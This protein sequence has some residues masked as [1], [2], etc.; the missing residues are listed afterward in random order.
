MNW[1]IYFFYILSSHRIL[2]VDSCFKWDN[3]TSYYTVFK[4]LT[5]S[6][7]VSSTVRS[8][9]IKHFYLIIKLAERSI[10]FKCK[11]DVAIIQTNLHIT[12]SHFFTMLILY[13]TKEPLQVEDYRVNGTNPSKKL[14][15]PNHRKENALEGPETRSLTGNKRYTS[16]PV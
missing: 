9:F 7:V 2:Y 15:P 11:G 6:F 5:I 10:F 14:M 3:N 16:T 13:K 12:R 8:E 1:S 4:D